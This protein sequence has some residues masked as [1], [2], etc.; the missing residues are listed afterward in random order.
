MVESRRTTPTTVPEEDLEE[1]L[2]DSVRL[3][4]RADV[5]V[6]TY[7]SGGLDSSLITALAQAET[8][9][10]LRTFSI[11]FK[12]P[13]YDE[14][15]HQQEVA[16][17]IGTR[18]H[19]VEALPTDIAEAFPEVVRH[20]EMPLVRTA[21]VPLYL[22]ARHVREKGI[23]VVA[24]GEG[25]D[26]LFWGYELFKEVV[27]RA[28]HR[29][30][31][32]RAVALLDE[33]YSY[34]GPAAARRGPAWRRFLLETGADDE[35]LGSHLTRA[36]ATAAVKAFYR[37]EVAEEVGTSPALDRLRAELPSAFA[38][39]KPLAR[40]AWLELSTLLEPYL[41]SAQGDRVA[42]AHGVEGRFPFLDHRVFAHSVRLPDTAEAGWDA[43]EGGAQRGRLEGASSDD[44]RTGKAAVPGAGDRPVLHTGRARVGRRRA[45]AGGPG[46]D[47]HLGRRACRR[48]PAPLS[49]WSCD[50]RARID[51]TRR[52]ALHAALAPRAR[53]PA[54]RLLPAGE[55][56]A[57]G[58]DR[59]HQPITNRGGGM[60]EVVDDVRTQMRSYIEENFLY[61]H[62]G[63]P[64]RGQR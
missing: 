25:A 49:C 36:H 19:V 54:G 50:R 10:E 15:S 43:R 55:S 32:E 34:L 20:A 17:A 41:L 59:S 23:T 38:R 42:M 31:P 47:G 12:D 1:L 22:L 61:L 13:R 2:R 28:L 14:R 5:P 57:A 62:P 45:L 53:R 56:G 21:P 48:A 9:H 4:L 29:R 24:T 35:Q 39:W 6:G 46:G 40:A 30:E 11:A 7:L 18:H 3:R 63:H 8:D 51:G 37:P 64:A 52:S 44:R 26:E 60:T 33:L 16:R 27:L 58:P